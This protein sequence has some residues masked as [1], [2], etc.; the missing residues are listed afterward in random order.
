MHVSKFDPWQPSERIC[1]PAYPAYSAYPDISL[2]MVGR[3]GRI[4]RGVET[5]D[6]PMP[7]KTLNTVHFCIQPTTHEAARMVERWRTKLSCPDAMDASRERVRRFALRF[8]ESRWIYRLLS[9]G[10]TGSDFF[11]Y[12]APNT[13]LGGLVQCLD[14]QTLRLATGATAAWNDRHGRGTRLYG[15]TDSNFSSPMIWDHDIEKDG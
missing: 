15:R 12:C 2:G 3:I 9:L 13:S 8:C 5:L 1:P 10:W 11:A 7:A 14:G 6:P 4:G